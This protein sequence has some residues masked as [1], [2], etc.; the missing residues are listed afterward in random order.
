MADGQDEL[1]RVNWD[2]VFGFS[3]VFKSFRM[4][5]HPSKL[6]LALAA[7]ILIYICGWVLDGIWSFGDGYVRRDAVAGHFYLSRGACDDA[8]AAWRESRAKRAAEEH[9]KAINQ[10]RSLSAYMGNM[11]VSVTGELYTAF[12]DRVREE[13]SEDSD[14]KE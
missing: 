9:G 4:A 13:N 1:R 12:G 8:R 10:K 5:I 14:W 7:I 2:E 6:L 11:G 3:H